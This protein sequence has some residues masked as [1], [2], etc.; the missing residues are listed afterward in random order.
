MKELL[1]HVSEGVALLGLDGRVL[2]M[3]ER[4][5][6]SFGGAKR[7]GYYYEVFRSIDLIGLLQETFN[8]GKGKEKSFTYKE[9][10][11]RA[12]TVVGKD[13]V[14]LFVERTDESLMLEKLRK[15]FLGALSHELKTPLSVISLAL[16][17]LLR[18]ERDTFRRELINRALLRAKELRSLVDTLYG[19]AFAESRGEVRLEEVELRGILDEI[20]RDYEERISEKGLS[21]NVHLE[22]ERIKADREKL[23]IVLR[24]VI[25]NAITYNKSGGKV[26]IRSF[27]E[28]GKEV[29]S[30]RDTGIGIKKESIPLVFEPFIRG[31]ESAG[32]GLGLSIARK[33]AKAQGAHLLIES[34][35]SQG[36][37]VRVVFERG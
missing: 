19:L 21:V 10:S 28:D 6:E 33:L 27:R 24:N 16:E 11:Y 25:D 29:I 12:R 36:T 32:L 8:E 37:E 9:G 7:E 4:M 34:T 18:D 14:G 17:T 26:E 23:R 31:E 35:P 20:L 30:V 5:R 13:W 22:L 1:E 15:E 2:F 3:N